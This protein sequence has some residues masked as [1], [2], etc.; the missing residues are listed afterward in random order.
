MAF[1]SLSHTDRYR[2]ALSELDAEGLHEQERSAPGGR[3]AGGTGGELGE[4]TGA[5]DCEAVDR[6][7]PLVEY[8]LD[9]LRPA[10]HARAACR[11]LGTAQFFLTS[12]KQLR[13]QAA[14]VALCEGCEVAYECL[15]YGL[16]HGCVGVW[17]GFALRGKVSCERWL[18]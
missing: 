4:P 5:P 8:L 15:S 9:D 11:G 18:R 1:V 6:L 12:R 14:T 3:T 13:H 17:G 7:A 2:L 10:W 16:D